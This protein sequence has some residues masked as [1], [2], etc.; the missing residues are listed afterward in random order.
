M[1]LTYGHAKG[2]K[3]CGTNAKF[4]TAPK[5]NIVTLMSKETYSGQGPAL[6]R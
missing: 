5:Q 1:S 6:E 4:A 2:M 3:G